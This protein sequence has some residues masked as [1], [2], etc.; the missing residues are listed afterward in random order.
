M[1]DCLQSKWMN[2]NCYL[3]FLPGNLSSRLLP[4]FPFSHRALIFRI[5]QQ[6]CRDNQRI[7]ACAERRKE[8]SGEPSDVTKEFAMAEDIIFSRA[9]NFVLPNSIPTHFDRTEEYKIGDVLVYERKLRPLMP[10]RKHRL[11]FTGVNISNLLTEAIQI[12]NGVQEVF[13]QSSTTRTFGESAKVDAEIVYA[14]A[15]LGIH[16]AESENATMSIDFG[17]IERQFSNLTDLLSRQA[18]DKKLRVL[19]DHSVI[20]DAMAH[21][22]TLFVI[23]NVYVAEKADVSLTF[24]SDSKDT[25]ADSKQ[26]QTPAPPPPPPATTTSTTDTT[27]TTQTT[28]VSS[29]PGATI[30]G[31]FNLSMKMTGNSG[32]M[33]RISIP[34][35]WTLFTM[36]IHRLN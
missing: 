18:A 11:V 8:S 34:R 20:K 1:V 9:V 22:K 6:C 24:T 32:E 10:W 36:L 19:T 3:L 13:S 16:I 15:H 29:A 4:L 7:S 12:D 25:G 28:S 2:A 27:T 30:S 14:I 31:D 26:V 21:S 23:N 5:H 35:M 33:P 17:K